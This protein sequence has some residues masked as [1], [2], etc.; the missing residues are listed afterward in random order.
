M[1]DDIIEIRRRNAKVEADKAWETSWLRRL[2]ITAITYIIAALYMI[3]VGLPYPF[4][5]AIV[6]AGGYL[7]STLSLPVAKQIWL[8]NY[9]NKKG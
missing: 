6:P 3:L 5:G 4:L 7:L 1:D 9:Y 2:F 8:Q